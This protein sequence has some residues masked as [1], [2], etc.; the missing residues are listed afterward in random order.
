MT[1]ARC[2]RL[3]ALRPDGRPNALAYAGPVRLVFAGTPALALPALEA[4]DAAGHDL[5][6][7]VTRP[8]AP[9]GRSKRL[10]PSP[11][12][13]W[14][15][16]HGIE[17]LKP[18]RAGDPSF[19]DRLRELRPDACPV[20]AYGA[21]LPQE[22]LALATH[23]WINVHFSLLPR[24]RGA[25]P[26]QR[27]IIERDAQAGVSVFRIVRELDAG[28]V[29]ATLTRPLDGTETAGALLEELARS[30][31]DLL[32]SVIGALAAGQAP[33]PVEQNAAGVT[34][35]PKLSTEEARLDFGRDA[36][37]LDAL[38][39]G[40]SPEPGAWTVLDGA[41]VKILDTRLAHDDGELAAGQ[42]RVEKRR[43]LVGTGDGALELVTVQPPGKKPM[44]AADW[45]RGLK[46]D[47]LVFDA[48]QG[49]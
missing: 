8:D 37:T 22:A 32:A 29:F 34:L 49:S 21:L 40:C 23:G 19:L 35:A 20:V 25:A 47:R 48:A 30:G 14:A 27:S 13:A 6:A 9:Q 16:D 42:L 28:P 33:D 43:V 24:H 12:A 31:A 45:G 3:S 17:T 1:S 39:R 7:V 46:G 36:L 44:A 5:A 41:R 15:S 18:E 2:V 11:V 4:L 26:A 10:V 38:A